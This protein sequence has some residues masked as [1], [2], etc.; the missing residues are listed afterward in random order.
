MHKTL[1]WLQACL[2]WT[3][4]ACGNHIHSSDKTWKKGT[5]D[6]LYKN[7]HEIC[8]KLNF[9]SLNG[10]SEGSPERFHRDNFFRVLDT[11]ERSGQVLVSQWSPVLWK[12]GLREC[13]MLAMVSIKF[14][15]GSKVLY[16]PFPHEGRRP[17][18][19][20]WAT[21]NWQDLSAVSKT[22]KELS[23]W[24]APEDPWALIEGPT[25]QFWANFIEIYG[26]L[27]DRWAFVERPT[28]NHWEFIERSLCYQWCSLR[29]H[30]WDLWETSSDQRRSLNDQ[31]ISPICC[32]CW[33]SAKRSL[34]NWWD[35]WDSLNA[36]WEIAEHLLKAC[37]PMQR[38]LRDCF[39]PVQNLME[40]MATIVF[41][42]ISLRNHGRS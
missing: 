32:I 11:A 7:L 38:P 37:F 13:Y 14:W 33:Q 21:K 10:P 34:K 12:G 41:T 2:L 24:N 39:E 29:D 35:R 8:W 23:L 1:I 6:F 16:G 22:P 5:Y 28:C 9:W 36:R 4:S 17:L 42:E 26:D 18:G 15:T 31:E 19:S 25:I 30:Y 20:T 3:Q 40:T 27:G